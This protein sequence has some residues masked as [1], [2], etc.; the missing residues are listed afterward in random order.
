[1]SKGSKVIRKIC[2]LYQKGCRAVRFFLIEPLVRKSF[3]SCGSNVRIPKGCNFSGIENIT[4]GHHVYFGEN[5]RV[6]TT[7]AQLIIGDYVMFGPNVTIVTGDHRVDVIGKYMMELTDNDKLPENDR[8]VVIEDDVWL[9]A[10]CTILKG[11]TI[12]RGSVVAAG[13]L[14]T[15]S[16]LPYS[17]IGGVPARILKSRFTPERTEEHEQLLG[18]N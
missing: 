2:G 4:V 18:I 15:Q 6:L 3:Q 10:N 8:D 1:M 9:G 7:K 12:G 5:T 14:V 13:A 17:I 11:V 16:C